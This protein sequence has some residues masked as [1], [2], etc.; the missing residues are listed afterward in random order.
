M[1]TKSRGIIGLVLSVS[2]LLA[3]SVPT[4]AAEAPTPMGSHELSYD[5]NSMDLNVPFT[6]TSEYLTPDGQEVTVGVSFTPA[7]EPRFGDTKDAVEGTWDIWMTFGIFSMSY[8]IDMSHPSGWKL[9]N[10]RNLLTSG[11]LLTVDERELSITRAMSTSSSPAT[12]TA[13]AH[14]TLF[15]NAWVQIGTISYFLETSVSHD[16]IVTIRF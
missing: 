8:D 16:G 2:L 1:N 7:P 4:F 14:C 12:A 9:S 10:A 15:D 5:L 3:C 13:V 6:E 11:I